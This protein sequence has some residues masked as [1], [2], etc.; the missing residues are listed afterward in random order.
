M[1]YVNIGFMVI[2]ERK[3][4]EIAVE[5]KDNVSIN[6]NKEVS[7]ALLSINKSVNLWENNKTNLTL[8]LVSLIKIV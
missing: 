2:A 3:V 4:C 5:I 6:I 8:Y 1:T 7:F